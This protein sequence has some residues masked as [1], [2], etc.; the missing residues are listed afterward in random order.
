MTCA[1]RGDQSPPGTTP[2]ILFRWQI[3]LDY[4]IVLLVWIT[5]SYGFFLGSFRVKKKHHMAYLLVLLALLRP[6]L[7]CK[8]V[9]RPHAAVVSSNGVRHRKMPP[10]R[11][12]YRSPLLL[13]VFIYCCLHPFCFTRSLN[14]QGWVSSATCWP[15][16]YVL[17]HYPRSCLV[18]LEI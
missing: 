10:A 7:H 5:A 4:H 9:P 17:R 2:Y 13:L 3:L 11:L 15:R 12:L 6:N 1:C 14:Y 8:T 18:I 16:A